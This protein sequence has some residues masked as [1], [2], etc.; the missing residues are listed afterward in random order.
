M[1]NTVKIR[2]IIVDDEPLARS[3]LLRLLAP[4]SV[5]DVIAEAVN[6]QEAVNLVKQLKPDLVFLDIQ[7]PI[8]TGLQAAQE[9]SQL[10]QQKPA[11]VFCTAYDQYAVEAFKTQAVAYLLKPVSTEDL[12]EAITK[13][14]QVS[15]LQLAQ[16]AESPSLVAP[17]HQQTVPIVIG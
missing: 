10:Q 7:M 6:G 17:V 16:F 8:K 2:T 15:Q 1:Q 12:Q 4:Q 11:I 14:T 3:R 13:A 5:V 9:I